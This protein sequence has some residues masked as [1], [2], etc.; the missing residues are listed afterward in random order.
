MAI[1]DGAAAL[2]HG[3]RGSLEPIG[4]PGSQSILAMWQTRVKDL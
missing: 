1:S 4:S 3:L 2:I